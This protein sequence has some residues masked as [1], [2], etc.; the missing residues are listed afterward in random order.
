MDS[1]FDWMISSSS[2]SLMEL[3]IL[4]KYEVKK[5]NQRV[6]ASVVVI[7]HCVN[8]LPQHFNGLKQQ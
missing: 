7:Y 4:G 2:K 3:V 6:R 8:K 1:S 5:D